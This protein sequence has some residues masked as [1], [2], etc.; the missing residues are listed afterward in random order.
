MENSDIENGKNVFRP[1]SNGKI[2]K[3]TPYGFCVRRVPS[4]DEEYWDANNNI[5]NE[6]RCFR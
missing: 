4:G 6:W 1:Q 3:W 5:F 2:D